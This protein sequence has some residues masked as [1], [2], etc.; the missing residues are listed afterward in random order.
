MGPECLKLALVSE[1]KFV[2]QYFL[3]SSIKID[4][5]FFEGVKEFKY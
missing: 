2:S 3:S 5:S 1:L 4:S